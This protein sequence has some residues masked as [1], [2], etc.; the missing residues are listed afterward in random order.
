MIRDRDFLS[1]IEIENLKKHYPNL[2]ILDYYCFENY[3][4]HPD[5]MSEVLKDK[6]DK[7][8]YLNELKNQ[9]NIHKGKITTNI[10]RARQSF[11]ELKEDRIKDK[12][13]GK[14][15]Y[16][17]LHSNDFEKMY[18]FFSMKDYFDKTFIQ[19]LLPSELVLVKTHWF[20]AK[21]SAIIVSINK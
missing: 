5:N 11:H 2:F 16:E 9:I 14:F 18:K 17:C 8:S 20:K 13:A 3:L 15:I 21:I 1:D 19:K 10:E 6:L 12:N 7:I 4:F